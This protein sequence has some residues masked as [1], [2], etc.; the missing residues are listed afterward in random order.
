MSPPCPL[1]GTCGGCQLQHLPYQRQLDWKTAVVR[2]LVA[3]LGLDHLVAP[4]VPS[5][6]V[7]GY[8]SKITPH[9]DRPRAGEPLAIG[10]LKIGRKHQVVDVPSC[11][12]ATEGI[13]A[14]LPEL[15]SEIAATAPRGR[16]GASFLIREAAS[17]VTTD[18]DARVTERV[19]ELELEFFAR[20]FFQNNPFLLPRLVDF[21]VDA[22]ASGTAPV[23][24]DTY[25]GSG[26]FALA[27]A[28]RF[29][30]VVGVEVSPGA[31][32]AAR[33]NAQRNNITNARFVTSDAARIFAEVTVSG[34]EA[35][36]IVDP[37][38]KGCGDALPV[39]ARGVCPGDD[40]VRIVQSRNTG[41]RL[42]TSCSAP[43]TRSKRC[44][45]S[46]CFPRPDTW[47]ASRCSNRGPSLVT[48]VLLA[49]AAAN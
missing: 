26:L 5:P 10:F 9:H 23:L 34:G 3:P 17:G 22:A 25:T 45:R 43:A 12:L 47:N 40:R 24:V 11:P 41:A 39:T 42:R 18:P 46:T 2:E 4:C 21:V 8:R 14:R 30:S 32:R 37:P 20:E 13:N 35:A 6:R 27:A 29:S 31:V 48:P 16:L 19:G 1:F 7:L 38:R 49:A 44:S 36:V 15:R 28:R 33:E